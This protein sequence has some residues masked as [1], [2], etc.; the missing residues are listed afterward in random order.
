MSANLNT[1]YSW[2]RVARSEFVAWLA[3]R[4]ATHG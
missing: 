3:E 2:L 1:V 4:G